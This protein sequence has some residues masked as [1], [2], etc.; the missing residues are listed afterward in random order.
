MNNKET[1]N[2]GPFQHHH[3]EEFLKLS[4]YNYFASDPGWDIILINE[5]T[6]GVVQSGFSITYPSDNRVKDKRN[7]QIMQYLLLHIWMIF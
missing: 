4:V 3:Q 1:D 2:S 7:Y 5:K 6:L